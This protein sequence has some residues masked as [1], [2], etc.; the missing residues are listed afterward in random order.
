MAAE[1]EAHLRL[2]ASETD[3]TSALARTDEHVRTTERDLTKLGHT[4]EK[5]GEQLAAGMNKS[6]RAT[7]QARNAAGQ[8]VPAANAAGNAAAASGAKAAI[9]AQGFKKYATSV[10][11]AKMIQAAYGKDRSLDDVA[12][13]VNKLAKSFGG[14]SPMMMLIKWGTILTGGQAAV[15]MLIALGAG[16]VMAVGRLAPMVGVLGALAP[17]LFGAGAMMAIFKIS[18]ADVGAILRPLTNDFKAMRMEITQAMVPGLQAFNREIHD[19]LVP[20]LRTGLVG[21]AGSFATAARNFGAM[22]TNARAVGQIGVIFKGLNPIIVML[23][24][25]VGRLFTVFINL[26]FAAMPM[27]TSMAG[28]IDRLT[29]RVQAW[30]D[31]MTNSGR[32]QGFMMRAWNQAKSAGHTLWNVLVGLYN[33]FTIAGHVAHDQFGGGLAHASEKF[34]QWTSS[35][36]GAERIFKYFSDAVP[37]LKATLGLFGDIAKAIG[38]VGADSNVAGL[39]TQIRTDLLPALGALFHNFGGPGGLGP[40]LVSAFTNVALALSKIP[41]DG[42]KTILEAVAGIAGAIGWL[43][44]NVPGFGQF[45]GLML[46]MYVISGAALKTA[47]VGI[48]AFKWVKDGVQGVRDL[49]LA[50]R[51][52]GGGMRPIAGLLGGIG[53]AAIGLGRSISIAFA[54]NPLGI[55]IIAIIA[56]VGLFIWAWFKFDWFREG[57]MFVLHKVWEGFVWLAKAAAAP[58]IE[59]WNIIKGAYNLIAMGWNLIPTIHVPDWIPFIGGKDFN[60]PKMPLLA[61]GGMI[62]YGMAIVGEQGPEALVKGGQFLG[63]IG[64]RGPEL[65]TDLPRGGYVV[66][67]LDTLA[68]GMFHPLPAAVVDTMATVPGY[69]ALLDRPSAAP[70]APR[71]EV[72]VDTGAAEVVDAVDRL[73]AVLTRRPSPAAE[74]RTAKLIASLLR[75]QRQEAITNR[76]RY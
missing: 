24:G 3:L 35:A 53:K 6:Q 31:A 32:A 11:Q 23:G 75:D 2:T 74:D 42:L 72:S 9:G 54:S 45:I 43:V 76:Y 27:V 71:V 33:I 28:G 19:R 49:G 46:S 38:R 51:V 41:L 21:M 60:L 10:S 16:A 63:M 58:F 17:A 68:S 39:I 59:L 70:G 56:L 55:L 5:T 64:T 67:S 22:I 52:L 44:A 14:L 34:R 47:G 48:K 57:V 25:A 69:G 36:A 26:A 4:G 37:I 12:K 29:T 50:W 66:P 15:G 7:N 40:A 13:R 18:G 1:D 20:T 65:R 73:T 61:Q 30:S 8:F 62:E